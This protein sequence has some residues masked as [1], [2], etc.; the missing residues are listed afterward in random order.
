MAKTGIGTL[1]CD[2][3]RKRRKALKAYMLENLERCRSHLAEASELHASAERDYTKRVDAII[4]MDRS[5]LS[6]ELVAAARAENEPYR[7]L[8][9]Q[10]YITVDGAIKVYNDCKKLYDEQ[11]PPW[12]TLVDR[13]LN[14][15]FP[16]LANH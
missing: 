14:S 8:C 15:R 16:W 13:W 4:A 7:K 9:S 5:G 2:P 1:E 12:T 10:T 3:P 11:F 6:E